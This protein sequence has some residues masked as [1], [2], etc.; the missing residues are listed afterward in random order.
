MSTARHEIDV[1]LP[2][3]PEPRERQS[4]HDELESIKRTLYN[5]IDRLERLQ[6]R[7]A[8]LITS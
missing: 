8:E 5:A 4:R 2:A 7:N 1:K 3:Q 6:Q